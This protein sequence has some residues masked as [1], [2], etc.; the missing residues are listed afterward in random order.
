MCKVLKFYFFFLVLF[1]VSFS[2]CKKKNQPS[3]VE[4]SE[5]AKISR[6]KY[7]HEK[8]TE[9]WCNL[10]RPFS[11]RVA[12]TKCSTI[13]NKSQVQVILFAGS[14]A[15]FFSFLF[16]LASLTF[17]FQVEKQRPHGKRYAHRCLNGSQCSRYESHKMTLKTTLKH[18]STVATGILGLPLVFT[19]SMKIQIKVFFFFGLF[20]WCGVQM[21]QVFNCC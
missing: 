19:I 7:L 9:Y 6:K 15:F 13:D 21:A 17:H 8:S 12:I 18:Y 20:R 1:R 2:P 11:W 3:R 16:V 14:R 4:S 10:V 5:K